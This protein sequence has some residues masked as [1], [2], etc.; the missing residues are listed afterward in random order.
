MAIFAVGEIGDGEAGPRLRRALTDDVPDVVWNA[1]LS[2]ARLGDPAAVPVL[3]GMLA[4]GVETA[5]S[6]SETAAATALPPIGD[7]ADDAGV[8][9]RELAL[10]AIRGLAILKPRRAVEPLQRLSKD[11]SIDP[12]LAAAA[13]LALEEY[14]DIAAA[15]V[16]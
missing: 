6:A 5:D 13:A 9:G 14:G 15:G 16:P 11:R 10:N 7:R 12:R 3:L 2:L 1:A 8:S 4:E